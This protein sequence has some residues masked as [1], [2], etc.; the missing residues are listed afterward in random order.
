MLTQEHHKKFKE[1]FGIAKLVREDMGDVIDLPSGGR[2]TF[3]NK[4]SDGEFDIQF[5][6]AHTFDNRYTK[7][8]IHGFADSY[9]GLYRQPA[10]I[11]PISQNK[12]I[13]DFGTILKEIRDR[14]EKELIRQMVGP[15]IL[16]KKE[17]K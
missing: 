2:M 5:A 13:K 12:F 3:I 8:Y 11:G 17:K 4:T 1:L 15:L 7:D 16:K 6:Y 9:N 14:R 10:T